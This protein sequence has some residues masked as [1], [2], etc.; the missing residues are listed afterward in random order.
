MMCPTQPPPPGT[1]C[2]VSDR[3]V[4]KSFS[5]DN[6]TV[7]AQRQPPLNAVK[8]TPGSYF[9]DKM[10]VLTPACVKIYSRNDVAATNRSCTK[11]SVSA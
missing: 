6:L 2:N 9:G 5:G 7:L 8:D 1:V 11:A 10:A 4:K 3:R